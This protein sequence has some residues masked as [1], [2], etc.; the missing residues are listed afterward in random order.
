MLGPDDA[1]TALRGMRTL[2]MRLAAHEKAGLELAKWVEAQDEVETVLHPALQQ[3]PDHDLWKRDFTGSNGLF[4][5][6]MKDKYRDRMDAFFSGFELFGFGFSWGGYES[7]IIPCD[8]QLHRS[9]SAPMAGPLVRIH[10]GLED[11]GDLISDLES[12]FQRLRAG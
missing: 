3:F 9:T 12:A 1:Y 4:G 10:A 6:V 8:P 7:L 2:P 11:V 5:F